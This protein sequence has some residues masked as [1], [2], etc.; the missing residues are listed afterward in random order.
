M[1]Q[2]GFSMAE[3]EQQPG[4]NAR[5]LREWI[6]RKLLPRPRGTGRGAHYSEDHILRAIAIRSLRAQGQSFQQVKAQLRTSSTSELSAIVEQD[7]AKA[8]LGAGAPK[9]PNVTAPQAAASRVPFALWELVEVRD[10]L[11]LLVNPARGDALREIAAEIYRSFGPSG[12]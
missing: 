11:V 12:R 3:F 2:G 4:V 9:S 5:L 7:K 10:G 1:Q 8:S 6:R